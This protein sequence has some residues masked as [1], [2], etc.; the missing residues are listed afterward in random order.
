[1][2]A[3]DAGDGGG[4][5]LS[6]DNA[7][8]YQ[9]RSATLTATS[10]V[11]VT[12]TSYLIYIKDTTS[13]NVVAWCASGVTCSASVTQ[14][15]AV[16]HTYVS[17]VGT[18]SGTTPTQVQ[19]GP[20]SEVVVT[21]SPWGGM[22]LTVDNANPNQLVGATLTATSP[23]NVTSTGFYIDIEDTTT[24]QAVTYCSNG[25]TCSVTVTQSSAVTHNYVAWV[26]SAASIPPANLQ[27]NVTAPTAVT[28]SPWGGMTLT[29]DNA[30][31]NQL[32]GATLTATSP[33][34]VTYTSFYINIED[35][36]TGQAVTYCSNGTTCSVTVTQSSAVTHN[37]VAWVG[38]A[39]SIPPANLQ[40]NVTAPT[41]VT[42]SPWGGMTLTVDNANPNQLVGATLTATSP[43]N[44]TYTSFYINIED[45]T[46]GQAVTYC[47][48][49]TTCSVTVTQS[50][51]VTHNYVAWV[52]SAASIPPANLQTNVT[53][54]TAVTWSP[55]G[56]MTL[57]VDNANPNQLVGAT[58]TATS[59]FNVTYTSFYINIE[60][61]TTGQELTW[62][63]NGTTCSVTVTQSSA[64][65]HNYVAWVGSAASIP[66]ANL[67]T[68]VTAPTA[69]TWSPWAGM[70]L[71]ASPGVLAATTAT[72]LTAVS[73]FNV[74]YTYTYIN[75]EDT[76][77][78]QE[79]T[80]CSNGTTCSVTVSQ[81]SAVTHNYVAWV[82]S[83]ASIPPA[84]L[85]TNV[86]APTAVE[87]TNSPTSTPIGVAQCTPTTRGSDGHTQQVCV[88]ESTPSAAELASYPTDPGGGA[89]ASACSAANQPKAVSRTWACLDKEV[90]LDVTTDGVP[91]G[92]IHFLV[93]DSQSL[94]TSS[95]DFTHYITFTTV[96]APWGTAVGSS[97]T[98]NGSCAGGGCTETVQNF[99]TQL[100]ST[101]G[102]DLTGNVQ[103]ATSPHIGK[104]V[105]VNSWIQVS[106][107]NPSWVGGESTPLVYDSPTVRCDD[108]LNQDDVL[109]INR[110]I[111]GCVYPDYTPTLGID[112][113][114]APNVG[115]HIFLAQQSGLP[116][117][118]ANGPLVRTMD[119]ALK[120]ANNRAAC[121]AW[122]DRSGGRTCDEYPF[123]ST[124]YGAAAQAEANLGPRTVPG[125]GVTFPAG[126]TPSTGPGGW[127]ICMVS[128]AENGAAGGLLAGQY[129]VDRV[130]DG[131]AFFV[132]VLDL[133]VSA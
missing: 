106:F 47:S 114:V 105:E 102:Q 43:F 11:N 15:S 122:L 91:S 53:A 99:S 63:S 104:F 49:G 12:Y 124:Q 50:S 72:T 57:T 78:G 127:S 129:V 60:D 85:Q 28:W 32:V 95:V 123:E 9:L 58:L 79:L 117:T 17:W 100:I 97:F 133:P 24:G 2:K 96:S 90:D 29:V 86:T 94:D 3:F 84:N 40:T 80:W 54:P 69:V 125:C 119:P 61:T 101:G 4:I 55:W 45:T 59:P 112:G 92:G 128:G 20:T 83:A 116:G 8:P 131:D 38:S 36:T 64:V 120:A 48:N 71:S 113:A 121:P 23:F 82:G 103:A 5:S 19:A 37:Y 68:N 13:G 6:V 126:I 74:T 31:P 115:R 75:I 110:Y 34:N 39:A 30:N 67:Q 10:A 33:F 89:D 35:T 73:P 21:W 76:T 81:S 132:T 87:W 98:A 52:G 18:V 70:R 130:L 88:T 44:V 62:C 111:P 66:P 1:M 56:G 25:T 42:W 16:T 93:S 118:L 14:S 107:L 41:A 7:N 109:P 108:A 46:T 77:T 27:T 65:T 22:T 26:G 51:A